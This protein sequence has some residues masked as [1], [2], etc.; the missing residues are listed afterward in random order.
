ML[1]NRKLDNKGRQEKGAEVVCCSQ[2][3]A[4]AGRIVQQGGRIKPSNAGEISRKGLC[5]SLKSEFL[6]QN[7]G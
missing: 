6:M 2:K 5:L 1:C 4:V 7:P 3:K